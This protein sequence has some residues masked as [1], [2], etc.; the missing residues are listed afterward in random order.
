MDSVGS[1][2]SVV[3]VVVVEVVE[4]IVVVFELVER[5]WGWASVGSSIFLFL[6]GL[7]SV[8]L[9][10]GLALPALLPS[11]SPLDIALLFCGRGEKNL[12]CLVCFGFFGFI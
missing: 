1:V 8:F 3:D 5:R 9:W 11:L 12:S 10:P 7:G 2:G 6:L 4:V